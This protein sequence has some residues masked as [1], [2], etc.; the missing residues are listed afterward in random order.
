MR[1]YDKKKKKY[2]STQDKYYLS[3]HAVKYAIQGTKN[4][5]YGNVYENIVAM[6]LIRRGY[7][8]YVGVLY[9][10]EVDFIASKR[11]E[12]IY[13][14]VSDDI[15]DDFDNRTFNPDEQNAMK[16]V[17]D[18]CVEVLNNISDL[19]NHMKENVKNLCDRL[20]EGI[21][22]NELKVNLSPADAYVFEIDTPFL[23]SDRKEHAYRQK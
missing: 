2:L 5:N 11:S 9:D 21:Q 15:G 1:R 14:Q 13:I 23:E 8:V 17:V 10:K 16:V 3:D 7:E 20:N 18:D 19:N 6:E 22:D 12:K 4:M